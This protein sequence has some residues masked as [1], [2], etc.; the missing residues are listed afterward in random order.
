MQIRIRLSILIQIWIRNLPQVLH[1]LEN[2]GINL[3]FHSHHCQF[4][5]LNLSRQLQRCHNCQYLRQYFE[6][7]LEKS[8]VWLYI[9]LKIRIRIR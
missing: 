8:S 1:M 4:I 9:L 6:I 3:D 7:F 5:L 2:Q